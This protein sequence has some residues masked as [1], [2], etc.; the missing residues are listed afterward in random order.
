[1]KSTFK[2]A[3]LL[4]SGLAMLA[5]PAMAVTTTNGDLLVGFYQIIGGAVQTNTYT[6]NLG[7]AW[8]YRENTLNDISVT[9]VNTG[10]VS[11]NIGADLST[12][13]GNNW[14]DSGTVYWSIYGGTDQTTVGAFNGD[15]ARSSY[16]SVPTTSSYTGLDS[17]TNIPV[18]GGSRPA[19][20]NS[21]EA[22]R[23]FANGAG[24]NVGN[25]AGAMINKTRDNTL[26]AFFPP[27]V[28][29]QLS[30]GSELRGLFGAG[31]ITGAPGLE[32]ALDVYRYTNSVVAAGVD[33]T[34][35]R[36]PG[37]ATLGTGQYIGTF[38]IDTAGNLGIGQISAIP[39]PSGALALGLIGTI[40]GLGYRSRRSNKL[41]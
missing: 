15:V 16:I 18:N 22:I 35:G 21:I 38:T 3:I 10:L 33:L 12:A 19:L 27:N 29:S 25:A 8:R 13:F 37:N 39:E 30:L 32:G 5:T 23:T 34:V 14:A 9:T 7:A 11:G 17:T 31:T 4:F 6:Y 40:A 28:P 24:T 1:M 41:A 2:T 20:S 36:T 26:D